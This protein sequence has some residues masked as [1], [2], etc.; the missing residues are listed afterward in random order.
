M[1]AETDN[2]PLKFKIDGVEYDVPPIGDLDMDEWEI[3]YDR[4]GLIMD[5][6][7]SFMPVVAVMT[8][9]V[10]RLAGEAD[11][12]AE[13]TDDRREADE[14]LAEAKTVLAEAKEAVSDETRKAESD[15]LR[16][17][18]QPGFTR[19]LVQIA[20]QR[21]HPDEK[22]AVVERFASKAKLVPLTMDLYE[23]SLSEAT[24]VPLVPTPALEQLSPTRTGGE[25]ENAS[26]DSTPRS[27]ELESHLEPT[28]AAA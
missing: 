16:R 18:A 23:Q 20:Y 8:G 6:F 11:S 24:P 13:G 27:D 9:E 12:F 25:N 26:T 10:L 2:Q 19:A 15:R 17:L 22:R 28:G 5:D 7:S 3:I 14:K 1:A 21:A 4:T